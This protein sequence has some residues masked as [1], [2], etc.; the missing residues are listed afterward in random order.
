MEEDEEEDEEHTETANKKA[1][2][3]TQSRASR[4]AACRLLCTSGVSMGAK[5][6]LRRAPRRRGNLAKERE[7]QSALYEKLNDEEQVRQI[8]EIIKKQREY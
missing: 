6:A 7:I 3:A 4:G 1:G 5:Q 2:R 8:F